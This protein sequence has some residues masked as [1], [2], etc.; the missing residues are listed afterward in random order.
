[1]QQPEIDFK[2]LKYFT[3]KDKGATSGQSLLD[4][5]IVQSRTSSDYR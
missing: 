5:Q 4:K 1:M 3:E 2:I